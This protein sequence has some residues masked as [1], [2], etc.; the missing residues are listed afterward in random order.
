[1]VLGYY[2]EPHCGGLFRGREAF[3]KG[4]KSGKGESRA[5][6]SRGGGGGRLLMFPAANKNDGP[7]PGA[8]VY[9]SSRWNENS[10]IYDLYWIPKTKF[11]EAKRYDWVFIQEVAWDVR[12]G[13]FEWEYIDKPTYQDLKKQRRRQQVKFFRDRK[14][15]ADQYWSDRV[16]GCR[17]VLG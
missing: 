11:W 17:S 16:L 2:T 5:A 1:M 14:K 13:D 9:I 7:H 6:S 15:A 4:H 8:Y 10:W 12:S 3:G